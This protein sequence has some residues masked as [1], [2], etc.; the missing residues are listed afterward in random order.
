M[1]RRCYSE[2]FQARRPTYTGCKV[3]DEWHSFMAFKSWMEQ[4]DWEG[5]QLDKDLIGDGKLYSPENCVFVSMALNGLFL[6]NGAIRGDCPIGV[7]WDKQ[8]GKYRAGIRVD[9]K[10]KHLGLFA[11]ADEA[12]EAWRIAKI[13]IANLFLENESNPRVRYAIECGIAKQYNRGSMR[14]VASD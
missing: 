4:Q 1:L 2:K 7:F 13:E 8:K 3:C 6:G 12:H 5:K 10:R 14:S 9:G 11:S